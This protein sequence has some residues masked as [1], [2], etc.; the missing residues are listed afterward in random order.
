MDIAYVKPPTYVT[1]RRKCESTLYLVFCR[2]TSLLATPTVS[3]DHHVIPPEIAEGA[4]EKLKDA[5]LEYLDGNIVCDRNLCGSLL[6]VCVI[7]IVVVV[8][9][10]VAQC[11][12]CATV[13]LLLLWYS[14]VVVLIVVVVVQ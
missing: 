13:L 7:V 8:V 9:V 1:L 6:F 4:V 12:C 3:H 5:F 11:Y 14:V 10:V 2:F